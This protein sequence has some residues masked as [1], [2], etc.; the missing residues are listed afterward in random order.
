MRS[1]YVTISPRT[2]VVEPNAF[3]FPIYLRY[4]AE[5]IRGSL[6]WSAYKTV[7][8]HNRSLLQRKTLIL[9]SEIDIYFLIN[10]KQNLFSESR[11]R[12]I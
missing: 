12:V 11:E 2:I 7:R 9:R 4:S 5:I 8:K 6:R 3:P 1:P 10:C